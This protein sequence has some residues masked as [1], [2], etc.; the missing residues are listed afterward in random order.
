[1]L[2]QNAMS[3]TPN[4]TEW[5]LFLR[6]KLCS[7]RKNPH[8]VPP[9]GRQSEI[10]RGRGILEV[11]ILEAKYEAQLEFPGGRGVQDKRTIHRGNMD[12]LWNCTWGQKS[13]A[14]ICFDYT[15][16]VRGVGTS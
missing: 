12:I 3:H 13:D 6:N 1:M 14:N 7:S 10:P 16:A 11:K 2:I 8:P 4:F 9:H 15:V 5:V